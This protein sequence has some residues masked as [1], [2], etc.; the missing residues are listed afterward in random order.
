[1][2]SG[3]SL[4]R[5]VAVFHRRNRIASTLAA[6]LAL[7]A[8]VSF[9]A[10]DA[11]EQLV[12]SRAVEAVIWSMPAISIREFVAASFRDYGTTWNDVV[13]FSKPAVA[14]H[15]LMTANNQVPYMVTS[16]NLR[17]GP[18]VVEIPPAGAKA[19]LFGSF[20]DTWQAPLADVGPAGEDA[21]KG[22]KYLFLPPGYSGPIPDGYIP[23]HAL[24]YLV[25]GGFRPVPA[26]GG[27]AE[28]AHTY[29]LQV[30]VYPL[31]EAAAPRPTRF[32]DGFPKSF[33]TLPAY[34]SSWFQE[35][36]SLVNDEPIRERDKVMMGMLASIGIERGKPFTPDAKLQ[37]ALRAALADARGLMEGY[38][39]TPGRALDP[40][41][42][43]SHWGAPSSN[44]MKKANA[45]T[46][47]TDEA[48]WLD[49]RAGGLFYW[50][51]FAPKKLGGSSFYLMGLRDSGGELLNGHSIYRLRVPAQVP[52]RDF[53][54]AI[55]Y[56]ADTK[57]F[58]CAGPCEQ[59]GNAVGLSSFDKAAMKKNPDGSVDL[60]FAPR[61]PAGYEKNWV[62]TAN[63]S[64]F[65]IFRLYGPEEALFD[66]SWKLPD[67]EKVH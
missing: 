34:D 58:V 60:Y 59:A 41:W 36:A 38:F 50:A 62:S 19:L 46:F 12:H 48:L 35:L 61:A 52:A 40:W 66:R 16:L 33:H 28:E 15:E 21:G 13:L 64:F 63:R 47:E 45:F 30:K 14:R 44:V 9:A 25:A 8:N 49:A 43:G 11:E 5:G 20:L 17:N 39:R 6:G 32:V 53:W 54:S 1:M 31:A 3:I 51:T 37:K 56:D 2:F 26:N 27:S 42:P 22:G 10:P 29:A 4:R 24:S 55:V 7:L 57:G 23:V 67:V 18:V 65:L